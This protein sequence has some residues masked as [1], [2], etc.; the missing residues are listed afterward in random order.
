MA[1]L[2]VIDE[3]DRLGP[4]TS[5]RRLPGT[6]GVEKE[7]SRYVRNPSFTRPCCPKVAGVSAG[8][9]LPQRHSPAGTTAL[10][11]SM[12]SL[13][14]LDDRLAAVEQ[15]FTRRHPAALA[16]TLDEIA[17]H[18]QALA[19]PGDTSN[20]AAVERLRH[21]ARAAMSGQ[22]AEARTHFNATLSLIAASLRE[23][24]G[25]VPVEVGNS[26]GPNT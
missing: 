6:H 11:M 26:T 13:R 16:L 4:R 1:I 3:E 19:K 17:D 9:P 25:E 21:A 20:P 18:V 2:V 12:D 15:C 22:M 23:F 14:W 7:A 8:I 10:E 24:G 5:H